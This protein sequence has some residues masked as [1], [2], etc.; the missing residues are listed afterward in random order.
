[1]QISPTI[2]AIKSA[3]ICVSA[4]PEMGTTRLAGVWQSRSVV[5]TD[6]HLNL[7]CIEVRRDSDCNASPDEGGQ[8]SGGTNAV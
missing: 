6:Q 7:G 1:M 5:N 3:D 4:F 8:R 2:R